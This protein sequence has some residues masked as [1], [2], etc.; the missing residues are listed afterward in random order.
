MKFEISWDLKNQ[1][2]LF[3]KYNFIK[4]K[5]INYYIFLVRYLEKI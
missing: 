5:I 3:K 1:I 2:N 4:Y